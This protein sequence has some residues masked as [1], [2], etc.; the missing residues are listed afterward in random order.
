VMGAKVILDRV[1]VL[2]QTIIVT[3]GTELALA[4][5]C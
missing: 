5:P 4:V 3:M 1:I 2:E